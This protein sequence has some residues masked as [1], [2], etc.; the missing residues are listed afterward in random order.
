M[1]SPYLADD[2]RP[3]AAQEALPA[4]RLEAAGDPQP[5][6]ATMWEQMGGPMGM[7][8][9]GLPVVVFVL[10][11]AL[12]SLGWA[13]GA[14][15]TAGLAI[16]VVRLVRKKP[17]TQAIAGLFGVALAAFIAHRTGSAKGF[18]LVGIWTYVA[19]GSVLAISILVRWPLIGVLWESLN[20]RGTTWRSD[21]RS[22]RRY[23]LATM[24]W[25]AV[26]GLRFAVQHALYDSNQVGWLATARLLMG[27]PLYLLAVL[28][29]VLIVGSA[30]GMKLPRFMSG[31]PKPGQVMS[32]R[33][34]PGQGRSVEGPAIGHHDTGSG[35][36]GSGEPGSGERGGGE[37]GRDTGGSD[38]RSAPDASREVSDPT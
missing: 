4:S 14:A 7:V 15:V 21:R 19:Y 28:A 30:S 11:N 1:S 27:Y 29:T 34:K 9:S 26:F 12:S 16:A 3:Q 24:V 2:D 32:G 17:V 25:L 38:T 36:P 37:P 10:V 33:P 5:G 31:R 13:I 35:E 8:D 23:D 20:G 22:V 6:P 18:F